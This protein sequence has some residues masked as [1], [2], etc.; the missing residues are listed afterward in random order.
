MQLLSTCCKVMMLSVEGVLSVDKPA[1]LTSHDV[2]KEVRRLIGIRRVGH[3]GTLDPLATGLLLICVGRATRLAEYLV[4]QD[5][6]Y[7]A[8][9]RLGQETDTYDAEGTIVAETPVLVSKSQINGGLDQFRGEITQI[10]PMFSAIKV[11]GQPLYRRARQ[12]EVI[13]RP[14]RT[15]NIHE[16]ELLSWQLPHLQIRIACSSGTYIRSIAH[17]LGQALGCGAHLTELRRTAV[18]NYRVEEA[19][20]LQKLD[21]ENLT[22]HLQPL[23]MAVRHLPRVVLTTEEAMAVFHGQRIP[24]RSDQA[25]ETLVRAYDEDDRFI[26]ILFAVEQQ[27]QARKILY[28]P[29]Q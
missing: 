10:P 12:G 20:S 2:V 13:Q 6:I 26:G 28:Q 3:T 17:D 25:D 14:T 27:W 9:I 18:G 11:E 15:V 23:D 22:E 16:L 19:V 1:G 5:K 29:A 4:G 24:C 7:L 8:T 21:P